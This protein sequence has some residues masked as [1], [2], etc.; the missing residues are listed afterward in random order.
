MIRVAII[1]DNLAYNQALQDL[2]SKDAQIDVVYAGANLNNFTKIM[3]EEQPDVVIMDIDLPGESGIQG[4][5][6]VK[7]FL[8]EVEVLM[9]T[10][11]EDEE[12]IFASVK[13]GA[14]GYLLKKDSPQK[15]IDAVKCIKNGESVMN[16][17]IA[18][19]LLQYFSTSK[20]PSKLLPAD[21]DLTQR[22]TQVLH[23]LMEGLSYKEIAR[24]LNITMDTLYSHIKKV[25]SKVN[26]HS[27]KEIAVK[28]K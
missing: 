11:F 5:A 16:G 27:R 4:V 24:Q 2:L 6:M 8:P 25:Y 15:I 19:K 14:I 10:V 1:E 17:T 20:K 23:L 26:V 28:F 22:E 21:Y 18:R 9:L 3:L 7:K 13:A 12:K